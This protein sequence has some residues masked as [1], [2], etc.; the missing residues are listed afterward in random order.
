MEKSLIGLVWPARTAVLLALFA[1]GLLAMTSSGFAFASENCPNEA[2]RKEQG[3]KLSDCRAYEMV[4]PADKFG[5][6]VIAESTR[7][8]AAASES[9]GLPA[10]V[11]FTAI[12]SG[13]SDVRGTGLGTEYLAARDGGAGTSGWSTH[14][15]TPAQDA[16]SFNGAF[17]G[18]EP[19]YQADMSGDLTKGVFHAWSPLTDAPNVTHIPSLYVREDLRTPGA[20]FYRLLADASSLLP[21]P[22]F[23]EDFRELTAGASSDFQHVVFESRLNLTSDASG[24]NVKL[25]KTDGAVT[26]LVASG[27]G[28]PGTPEPATPCSGAG[29]GA[30]LY[31]Y[32]QRTLSRDGSRALFTAPVT[33]EGGVGAA[34][35][36][37]QLDDRG[38]ISKA[39]DAV[40]QISASEAASPGPTRAATWQDASADGSRVFFTSAEQ[41]TDVPG[42]GLY[43]W[44][45]QPT[46]ETQ[47][48]AVDAIG[49]TFT[50]TA[51]AQP[52]AG[53]GTLANGSA[54][55]TNV[56]GT[57]TVGQTISAPDIPSGT[58]VVAVPDGG[59]LTLSAPAT[60]DGDESLS[61]SV[62]ATTAPLPHD[63][64]AAQVQST[65]EGLSVIGAGNVSVIGGPGGAGGG[66]AY[67][68]TFA[69]AL[70]GVN[71]AQMT[72]DG[73]ALSGG[74]AT[75]TVVTTNALHNLT[76]IA[77][78]SV[79]GVIGASDDGHRMYFAADFPQ[80]V[81][82]GAFVGHSAFYYWQ[83]ADGRPGG[84]L[85]F[86]GGV[87]A[88]GD[89]IT[90]TNGISANFAPR[91]SRVT[92]DG[93]FLMFEAAHGDE[94]RP[95]YDQSHCTSGNA[96]NASTGCSEAY[97]YRAD[98]S[99]PTDPDLVCASCN[100][101]GAPA[102]ANAWV[103]WH[104]NA[105]TSV[106]THLS[107][108]FSDDGRYVFFSTPEAL[109][110]EDVN[111][112]FD[113]YEYDVPAGTTRLLSSG[114]DPS[115]SFFLDASAN[116]RDVYFVTRARLVGWD[117][118]KAFDLYDARVGGGFPEPV[119]PPAECMG[120]AC[121][122]QYGPVSGLDTPGS[123]NL[124]SPGNLKPVVSTGSRP[125]S[126]AQKLKKALRVCKSHRKKSQRRKCEA[127]TRKRF[128]KSRGV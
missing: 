48:V 82:G 109:V 1:T 16:L 94:L 95:R 4:S 17:S 25:Y 44:A 75:A 46:N 30:S 81:P 5:N 69:G 63:A 71:V 21:A 92:P 110:P 28:C 38:T 118:D 76:W 60:A 78:S 32:T 10:A 37:F 120:D 55:V 36:V 35:K 68:V 64:T 2:L 65:L 88:G 41:L 54:T 85:S 100:P 23:G 97:V 84:T 74:A 83:D 6:E 79:T 70:A 124:S 29:Q 53:S 86:V 22:R 113:V 126:K 93:R 66:A 27:A 18:S 111:G 103:N 105:A 116:G 19:L 14:A 33:D 51:H 52:S 24:S 9:P 11:A 50:L 13:F 12:G 8:H 98:S 125:S 104:P 101:S 58:T 122:G 57:F 20:G 62:D 31:T 117:T 56:D 107:H 123:I 26:R 96:N 59:S 121:Q 49:G 90:N 87:A 42:G 102:T 77:P 112:K 106:G 114:K 127:I 39:D 128:G 89:V 40:V 99:T 67:L 108:A 61:A 34:S 91:V 15:I 45:R 73:S 47:S 115:D 7:T 80:L 119:V 43:M 72:A 3:T